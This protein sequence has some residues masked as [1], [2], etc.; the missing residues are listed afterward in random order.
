M[1]SCQLEKEAIAREGNL[2][3]FERDV[4]ALLTSLLGIKESVLAVKL[5]FIHK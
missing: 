2:K 5:I 1:A 4:R 3:I